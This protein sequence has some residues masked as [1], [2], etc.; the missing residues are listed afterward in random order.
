M[1]IAIVYEKKKIDLSLLKLG[2]FVSL[3]GCFFGTFP[4]NSAGQGSFQWIF[5]MGLK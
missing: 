2:P 4:M 1:E 3:C 5:T